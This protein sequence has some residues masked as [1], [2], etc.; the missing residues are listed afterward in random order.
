L[1]LI[2]ARSWFDR[3]RYLVRYFS[4]PG[5]MDRRLTRMMLAHLLSNLRALADVCRTRMHAYIHTRMR[6]LM[7]R[8]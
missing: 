4:D 5:I 8:F 2:V 3:S 1:F 7:P 6:V